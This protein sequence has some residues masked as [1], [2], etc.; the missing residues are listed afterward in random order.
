MYIVLL[1]FMLAFLYFLPSIVIFI[2]AGHG[3]V[4]WKRFGGGTQM[5]PALPEGAHIIFPWDK[6]EIYSLRLQED[7]RFY[8]AIANDGLPVNVELTM[9]YRP[10]EEKLSELHKNIGPKYLDILLTPELGSVSREIVSRFKA[11]EL[12]AQRR[13]RIQVETFEQ[14]SDRIMYGKLAGDG[15][16]VKL[17]RH[18]PKGYVL[19]H[20]I[21][22][23]DITLPVYI[24]NAIERKI[25]QDQA[26]Q[27]YQFRLQKETFESQRKQIEAQGIR[28]F[29]ETVQAGLTDNYLRWRGI[30]ATLE[31]TYSPNSKVVVIGNASN[32]SLPL[33]MD[34]SGPIASATPPP[35]SKKT[36]VEPSS[37][38][39]INR[40]PRVQQ[41]V[42]EELP[43][44]P[45]SSEPLQ[46]NSS[47]TGIKTNPKDQDS[48]L[49]EGDYLARL[50]EIS[51]TVVHFMRN[52]P[53]KNTVS[54][55]P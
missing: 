25:E 19:I 28:A 48:S 34:T 40:P 1:V 35:G 23:R 54:P 16:D 42:A 38:S 44:K 2:P 3:G 12:Y 4:L 33:I 50:K 26:A 32:G 18:K 51:N 15:P 5:G 49:T 46:A 30:E 14:L 47:S 55:P 9:R 36:H 39:F 22:I 29:Q 10:F 41:R 37:S 43:V 7:T 6:I 8:S 53:A 27:E 31:L 20:D 24:V 45:S 21:L 11:D 17:E 52:D 13:L